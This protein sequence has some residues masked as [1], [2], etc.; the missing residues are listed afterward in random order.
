MRQKSGNTEYH[1]IVNLKF[2]IS[3]AK[4]GSQYEY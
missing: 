3:N 2:T 4:L 1:N